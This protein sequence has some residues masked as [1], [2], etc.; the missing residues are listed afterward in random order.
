MQHEPDKLKKFLGFFPYSEFKPSQLPVMEFV[1][2]VVEKKGI[3]L[4]EAYCGFGKTIST[5][6]PVFEA[7]KKV[8]LLSPTHTARNAGI[9]EAL[10]INKVN[11]KKLMV[12]DLRS[13]SHMCFMFPHSRFSYEACWRFRKFKECDFFKSTYYGKELSKKAKKAIAEAEALVFYNPEKFFPENNIKK[14][15]NFFREVEKISRENNVCFYEIMKQIIQ[16]AD[17]VVLDYYWCFTELF[18]SLKALINPKDF[19]LLIDEADLLVDRLYNSLHT[20]LAFQGVKDLVSQLKQILK[21]EEEL[22]KEKHMLKRILKDMEPDNKK[23]AS[24]GKSTL[25]EADLEFLKEFSSHTVKLLQFLPPKKPLL[26]EKIMWEYIHGFEKST[27]SN[28]LKTPIAF[29]D[30]VKNIERITNLIDS[31]NGSEKARFRPDLFLKRLSQIRGSEQHITFIS[32]SQEIFI[33]PFE[34]KCEILSSGL[35][36]AET[37]KQFY[38]AILFSATIG[39]ENLFM[40]EFGLDSKTSVFKLSR[41]PH[42]NLT[43]IIDTELDSTFSNRTANAPKYASKVKLLLETDS[44]LLVSCCNQFET[45]QIIKAIPEIENATDKENL[46]AGKPYA[47]NIRTKHA[48]STNKASKVRNCIVMGLPLPDYSDFYFKQR[49]N[50]LEEKYGKKHTGKLINRKAV[51]IAVQLLGRITRDLKNP[52]AL[53]LADKRYKNDYFLQDFYYKIIPKYLKPYIQFA[54][55][56]KELKTQV[57]GFWKKVRPKPRIAA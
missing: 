9:A 40:E 15:P 11:G 1:S 29:D 32:E 54:S 25:N 14:E 37:L 46:D 48:R 50:Y 18:A 55:N 17:L 41:M 49:K 56:N 19:V 3:G 23:S 53:I 33:K 30:I 22:D 6:A 51:D 39:D 43:L 4:V 16:K 28:D 45:N 36:A 35:T 34:I 31:D 2:N 24:D 12:A 38:S 20:K 13:K 10:R 21:D 57:Q 52:K 5:L 27:Q 42:E 26:P 47:L 8:L 44:S 7:G